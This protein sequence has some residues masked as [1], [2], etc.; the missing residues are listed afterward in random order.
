MR[1][2]QR[3]P[4]E[5]LPYADL[6]VELGGEEHS[7]V[8]SRL[9]RVGLLLELGEKSRAKSDLRW[10]VDHRPAGVDM[11]RIEEAL[12]QMDERE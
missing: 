8:A 5:S 3:G 6:L 7:A 2:Q 1:E 4:R 11:E 10:I 12:R 9:D